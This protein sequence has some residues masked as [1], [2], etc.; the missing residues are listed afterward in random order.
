[1]AAYGAS[2]E[3]PLNDKDRIGLG[4]TR[5]LDKPRRNPGWQRPGP[6]LRCAYPGYEALSAV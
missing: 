2:A 3:Q 5:S 1:M 6:G 4:D